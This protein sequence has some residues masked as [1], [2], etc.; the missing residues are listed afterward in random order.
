MHK[1]AKAVRDAVPA[2][3]KE[4]ESSG[5]AAWV[6]ALLA[7]DPGH[8]SGP[9]RSSHRRDPPVDIRNIAHNA[10]RTIVYSKAKV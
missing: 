1:R 8:A 7:S 6:A 2:V 4:N 10:M 9:A 3:R 5:G